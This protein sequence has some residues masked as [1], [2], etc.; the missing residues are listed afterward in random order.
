MAALVD[1]L[2]PGPRWPHA[3]IRFAMKHD[4]LRLFEHGHRHYGDTVLYDGG[5][6]RY[7]VLASP[8][9]VEHI[10][11]R[12]HRAYFK[13]AEHPVISRMLGEGVIMTNGDRW[14][15]QRRAMAPAFQPRQLEALVQGME[16]TTTAF[17]DTWLRCGRTDV[18]VYDELSILTRRV[19]GRALFGTHGDET[20]GELGRALDEMVVRANL[21][22][23]R[24]WN[25]SLRWPT[26]RNRR[27]HR[28][29]E[30]IDR[31][32]HRLIRERRAG[33]GGADVL[34]MLMHAHEESGLPPM[35]DEELRDQIL[36]LF[37]AGFETSASAMTW[38]FLL[39]SR[40]PEAASRIAEEAAAVLGTGPMR[41]EHL[42]RLEYL[43]WVLSEAMRLYP[44]IWTNE[45]VAQ[46]DDAI[47]GYRI[48]R[49]TMVAVSTW[50]LHRNPTLWTR[51]ER[52]DPLR[53]SPER[54]AGR[55]KHAFV[56]FGLGPRTCVGNHFA[57]M[58]SKV[59][60]ATIV[61]RM[62]IDVAVTDPKPVAAV[63]LRPE[64]G[65]AGRLR[66]R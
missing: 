46:E 40:H 51:P 12:N 28:S 44:P 41:Y 37:F 27:F 9:G 2:P 65:V 18:D 8:A 10:L 21:R 48:P 24:P 1:P 34:A 47:D 59:M 17:V 19:V 13:S 25:L 49:G 4:P 42:A 32:V 43:G 54:S 5:R 30:H 60:V 56:P 14:R 16:R 23:D 20:G 66:V 35:S 36:N 53:F 39:L 55:P 52:F 63:T 15:Q 3:A 61:R 29:I 62:I 26:L 50:L 64:G 7:V 31:F 22:A 11:L 58:Q 6:S 33:R 45:R 38:T 57:T